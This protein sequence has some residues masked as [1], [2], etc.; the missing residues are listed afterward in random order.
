MALVD[1]LVGQHRLAD[2]V[3][4]GE[5][6]GHVGAQLLVHGDEAAVVDH[7]PGRLR[8][9]QLAAGLAADRHQHL[10]EDQRGG[11]VGALQETRR[12]SPVAST[13]VTLVLR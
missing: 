13:L 3:A 4:D 11:G 6:V 8:P 10:V 9:D 7:H 12:P 1:R 5:D 2:H